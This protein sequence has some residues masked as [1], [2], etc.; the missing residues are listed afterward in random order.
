[1]IQRL[2]S[3]ALWRPGSNSVPIDRSKSMI[4]APLAI[5]S[6]RWPSATPRTV[7]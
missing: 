6:A 1:M 2:S 5:A 3:R 7:S 4:Q